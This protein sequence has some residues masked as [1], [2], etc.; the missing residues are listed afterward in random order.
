VRVAVV[1][2]PGSNC[3]H[4]VV[5]AAGEILGH[6]V[7]EVWHQEPELPEADLVVLPGGFSYGDYL[8]GG[9]I[10]RFS[11]I[12]PAVVGRARAGGLTLGICNGFQVLCESGLLPGALLRNRDLRFLCR[13]VRLRVE[14]TDTPF[15]RAYEEGQVVRIPIAH[16]EGRYFAAPA[17]LDR[18]ESEGRIPLRYCDARGRVD[19]EDRSANCNGSL[20]SVAGVL[21]EGGNVLGMMPHPERCS[22]ALLGNEDGRGVFVSVARW[23]EG[24]A[25]S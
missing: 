8:R 16:G 9:A 24:R 13:D 20:R 25:V 1:I 15:T 2:F 3:D 21:G 22:E 17:E 23:L 5:R 19:A 11:P 10:A 12:M 4:D 7:T 14:R 6:E 18:L